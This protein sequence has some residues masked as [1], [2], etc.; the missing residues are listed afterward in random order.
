[1]RAGWHQYSLPRYPASHSCLRLQETDTKFLYTWANEWVVNK[2]DSVLVQGTPV[3][4]FGMYNFDAPKPWLQL[5]N[6]AKALDI[7]VEEIQKHAAPHLADIKIQQQKR[8]ALPLEK[9]NAKFIAGIAYQHLKF[10]KVFFA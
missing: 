4:V 6:N 10:K 5:V 2:K 8:N 1:M 7:P 9:S 3:I